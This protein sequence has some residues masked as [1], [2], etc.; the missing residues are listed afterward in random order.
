MFLPRD[1]DYSSTADDEVKKLKD[2]L[3]SMS[4]DPRRVKRKA[5]P[6]R[7][8]LCTPLHDYESVW[9]VATWVLFNCRP[10]SLG[11]GEL[12]RLAQSRESSIVQMFNNETDRRHIITIPGVFLDLKGSL[13]RI[14]HP[15]FQIL[16]V[17]RQELVG[18]YLEYEESFDGSIILRKVE[19]FHQCLEALAKAATQIEIL[20]FPRISTIDPSITRLH[21]PQSTGGVREVDIVNASRGAPDD[22]LVSED[23]SNRAETTPTLSEERKVSSP[24]DPPAAKVRLHGEQRPA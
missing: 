14:L 12:D 18:V 20:D 21:L 5:I 17:F 3:N 13:P 10:K 2:L 8:F 7:I 22:P 6:Q 19:R 15:L 4:S 1:Y 16:D 11:S 24:L 9:W 23:Q